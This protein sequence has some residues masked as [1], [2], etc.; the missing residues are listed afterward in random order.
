[1]TIGRCFTDFWG[2]VRASL[3]G[4]IVLDDTMY[5]YIDDLWSD[6]EAVGR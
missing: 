2:W 5:G 1:M 3:F 6:E 4:E